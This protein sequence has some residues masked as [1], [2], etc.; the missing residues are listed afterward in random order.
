MRKPLVIE[1]AAPSGPEHY[2]AAIRKRRKGFTVS[3]IW[4]EADGVSRETVKR[5]VWHLARAGFVQATAE[6]RR[7][8]YATAAVYRLIRD[9]RNAPIE[10]KTPKL[11]AREAMWIAIRTLAQFSPRELCAAASTD[12]RRVSLRSAD[13]YVQRLVQAGVLQVLSP[14]ERAKGKGLPAKS[15]IYRLKPSANS[16]PRAPKLMNAGFVFD[17]NKRQVVGKPTLVE[18][19]P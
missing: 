12:E 6:K 5:Y 10:N 18:V 19:S 17:M 15:G 11:S 3:D 9:Q 7:D 8:G 1:L 16:G 13:L 2:W 14:P 4:L